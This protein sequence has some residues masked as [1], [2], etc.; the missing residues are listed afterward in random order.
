MELE[1]NKNVD[2]PSSFQQLPQKKPA[3]KLAVLAQVIYL[4]NLLALPGLSFMVLLY[5]NWSHRHTDDQL[6]RCHLKK[7]V[8]LSWWFL[9]VV[10]GGTILILLLTGY[11]GIGIS[12]AIL[13]AIVMHT[14]FVLLGV[15]GLANAISG[16]HFHP[17]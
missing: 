4:A 3:V 6:G 16:K 9:L 11:S 7:T 2:K 13:Y 8:R 17:L 10:P 5:L 1:S 14:S 12:M 15:L